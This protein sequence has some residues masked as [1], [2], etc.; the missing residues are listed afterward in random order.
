MSSGHP[1][2]NNTNFNI[3]KRYDYPVMN[4]FGKDQTQTDL[5]QFLMSSK[6][7]KNQYERFACF[8]F[9]MHIAKLMDIETALT[10]ARQV[11][12]EQPL[13]SSLV[14]LFESMF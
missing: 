8:Q 4:R 13:D 3:L 9:M 11:A 7:M 2:D 5:K 1:N 12:D 14:E 6:A 10:I